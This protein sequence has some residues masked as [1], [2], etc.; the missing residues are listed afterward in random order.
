M[1]EP[2]ALSRLIHRIRGRRVVLSADLA[3]LYGV[4]PKALVQA[5]KR[6]RRRFPADFIFQLSREEFADLKSQIVTS[7]WG[8]IRRGYPYAFTEEGVAMLSSVL[9]SWRAVRVNIGIMR[10]FVKMREM[11]AEHREMLVKLDE[12]GRRVDKHDVE[13][14]ELIDA[15]RGGCVGPR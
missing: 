3:R 11:A 12:L 8:G 13:I 15:I 10:A 2:A 7:S 1:K 5:V 4:A 9:R 14:G 6:N